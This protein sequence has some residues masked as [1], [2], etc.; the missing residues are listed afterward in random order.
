MKIIQITDTHLSPK[1][2][3]FNGNWAPLARWIEASGADIV[4]HTGDLTIDGADQEEDIRFSM[5]LM[6]QLSVPVLIVPGNHDVGHYSDMHQPVNE[7]RL[8][9]WRE[10]AGPDRWVS[11]HGNWRLI[12]LN[13]LLI[14]FDD[15]V[16]EEQFAW[17]AEQLEGRNGRKVAI[18]A[19]K[20]LFVDDVGEGD[21]G[22]WSIRPE[23]RRRLLDL[24]SA[25]DVMLH[26]SGHLHWGWT[27]DHAGISLVWGPPSSFI[28]RDLEREM[29]G[30][31]LVGAVIHHFDDE[32]VSSEIIEL[33]D[34][35]A[36]VLDDVVEQVYPQAAKQTPEAAE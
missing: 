26:A 30:E 6:R 16:D 24:F 13:S 23:Q 8:A 4:V 20:P 28:L 7:A 3:H 15:V 18:F 33:A 34:L 35:T 32:G 19:H 11:D 25:N 27:G 31:R 17:L 22:Y 2:S 14:G 9:R 1:K 10:L 12:G 5:D 36:Y 21:T 29:P